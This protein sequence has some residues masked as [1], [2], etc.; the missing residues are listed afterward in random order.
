[1][2]FLYGGF[3]FGDGCGHA[4][5]LVEDPQEPAG[6]DDTASSSPAISSKLHCYRSLVAQTVGKVTSALEG[7][8]GS[9]GVYVHPGN[10]THTHRPSI[11]AVLS[12][13]PLNPHL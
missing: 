11:P 10:I 5:H 7:A 6:E 3:A 1:M 2:V 13:E 9:S 12:V 4:R 8:A